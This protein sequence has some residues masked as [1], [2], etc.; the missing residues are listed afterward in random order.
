[1]AYNRIDDYFSGLNDIPISN[2]IIDQFGGSSDPIDL[3]YVQEDA[4][5][6]TAIGSSIKQKA[7]KQKTKCCQ[8]FELVPAGKLVDRVFEYKAQCKHFQEKPAWQKR[9]LA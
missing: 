1:M 6:Q 3:E 8:Y 7:T 9:G 2:D 4:D 5:T